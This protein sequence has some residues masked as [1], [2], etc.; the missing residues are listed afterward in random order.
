[1]NTKKIRLRIVEKDDYDFMMRLVNDPEVTR[2]IR[3]MITNPEMLWAWIQATNEH[4]HEYIVELMDGTPIGEC[5]IFEMDGTGEIG[6]M[7]LS[8]YW[9]MGYG[10][11]VVESLLKLAKEMGVSTV[12][13]RTDNRN[14]ASLRLLEKCGFTF[15]RL[16]WILRLSL[17]GK[18]TEKEQ[19]VVEYKKDL[20]LE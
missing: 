20:S 18:T 9:R 5:S 12:M 8:A 7:L 16:G 1:M 2:Y 13:A 10:T 3:G 4:D 6:C 19:A 17:L 15:D 14:I 11:E